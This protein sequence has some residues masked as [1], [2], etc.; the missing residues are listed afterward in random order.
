M[1]GEFF[2]LQDFLIHTKGA[3]YLLSILFI[4]AFIWFSR[5]LTD[6]EEDEE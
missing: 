3:T 4:L 2:T 1:N 5:F 6:R